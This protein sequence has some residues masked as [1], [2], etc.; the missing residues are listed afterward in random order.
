MHNIAKVV[1]TLAMLSLSLLKKAITAS[2]WIFVTLLA[3]LKQIC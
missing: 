3:D 1:Y 2:H